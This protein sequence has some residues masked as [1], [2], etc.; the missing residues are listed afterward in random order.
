MGLESKT[1]FK[2]NRTKGRQDE[3]F[4]VHTEERETSKDG[5][6]YPKQ[7]ESMQ[8]DTLKPGKARHCV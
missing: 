8:G 3:D 2:T 4:R 1:V 7:A 6:R 5:W